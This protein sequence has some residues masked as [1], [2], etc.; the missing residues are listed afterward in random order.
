MPKSET[1]K[2]VKR[3]DVI[4]CAGNPGQGKTTLSMA[5]NLLAPTHKQSGHEGPERE[6]ASTLFQLDRAYLEYLRSQDDGK[7]RRRVGIG[8]HFKA[9]SEAE[10]AAFWEQLSRQLREYARSTT[11]TLIIEGV[12]ANYFADQIAT[13]FRRDRFTHVVLRAGSF[14][15]QGRTFR[16]FDPGARKGPLKD[17]SFDY[18]KRAFP[19]SMVVAADFMVYL[20]D[21]AVAEL[22]PQ[23]RYQCFD[24]LGMN[25]KGS[26]SPAKFAALE[27]E[28]VGIER[29]AAGPKRVLDVGCQSGN[30]SIR[31]ART[32]RVFRVTGIDVN[33][34]PLD[35]AARYNAFVYQL[36]NVEFVHS[37]FTEYPEAGFDVIVAASVFHY[38]RE[39]QQE[40][41]DKAYAKLKPGGFLVLECGLSEQEPNRP[42]VELYARKVDG[43]QPCHFPNRRRLEEMVRQFEIVFERPS[44]RQAG[45]PHVRQVFH[46]QKARRG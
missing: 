11:F 25:A 40:F 29:K 37:S 8:K 19:A 36:P 18:Y 17:H 30:F 1:Q 32:S 2:S 22:V 26:D 13:L 15:H 14:E 44:V 33:K 9:L 46:L 43:D 16:L 45:D 23:T 24:D 42:H 39:G 21:L 27:L 10:R 41:L 28:K 20:R 3:I 38:F 6:T 34:K 31:I 7:P 35:L 12:I 4:L 5:M